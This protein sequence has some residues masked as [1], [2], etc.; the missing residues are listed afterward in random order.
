MAEKR[1]EKLL[2]YFWRFKSHDRMLTFNKFS[3]KFRI[4]IVILYIL[5]SNILLNFFDE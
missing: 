2:L 4:C 3:Q 1:V 5:S